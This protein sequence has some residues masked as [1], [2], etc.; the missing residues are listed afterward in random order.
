MKKIQQLAFAILIL[1][2]ISLVTLAGD[3]ARFHFIGFSNAGKYL[4][5]EEYGINDDVDDSSPYSVIYIVN[6]DE[7]NFAVMPI[8]AK[9]NIDTVDNFDE[10]EF[11]VRAKN[12]KN[13]A[14]QLKKFGI[15]NGNTGLQVAAHLIN[16]Y[17][18]NYEEATEPTKEIEPTSTPNTNSNN[19]PLREEKV[20]PMSNYVTFLPQQISFTKR[21]NALYRDGFYQIKIKPVPVTQK[22]CDE[23]EREM[24]SFEMTLTNERHETRVLQ[25]SGA[26]PP[27]RGCATGYGIQEAFLY[28]NKLV[29]F[30]A[31]FTR[32]W[33]G[34]NLRLMAVTG[35]LDK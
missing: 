19:H 14:K 11:L 32:G 27:N 25:K 26:V 28:Q 13:A 29:V 4:A 20:D 10:L 35:D 6:V 5:F 8:K 30:V 33:E 24:F 31:I 15:V 9:L 3:Y 23:Y 16:E 7:N 22:N 1:L 17:D 18:T 12:R 34:E 21:G 2:A